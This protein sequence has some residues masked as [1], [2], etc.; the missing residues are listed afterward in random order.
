M[1]LVNNGSIDT[2]G[3]DHSPYTK[4][5]KEADKDDIFKAPAGF[6]GIELR[7]PLLFTKVKE[8]R[9][10]LD[11]MVDLISKNP[12]KIF[13]LYPRKGVIAV[14][15]DA[16]FV[17]IDPNKKEVISRDRMFTKAKDVAKVYEGWKVY[18]KPET[19][20]VRGNVV[21]EG[22]KIKVSPGYGN[23]VKRR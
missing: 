5:E 13:G 10:N 19:T 7:L 16:D 20:I 2:I 12:A 6:P 23:V 17:I 8:R 22:G 4:E 3:S 1:R 21:F 14:G 11:R 9:L 18:G 15:A